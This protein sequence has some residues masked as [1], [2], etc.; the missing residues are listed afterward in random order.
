MSDFTEPEVLASFD[1]TVGEHKEQLALEKGEFRGRP[2]YC[3]RLRWQNAE[4]AWRWSQAKASSTGRY[5]A[6]LTVKAREL[7]ELGLALVAE[8]DE[9]EHQ[10]VGRRPVAEPP[11]LPS[12]KP[13]ECEQREL[14]RFDAAHPAI[15]NPRG[16]P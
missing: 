16:I 15:A 3:L 6:A 1:R 11:N 8:A 12:R 2:T 9:L 14:D 7:R 13:S 10:R 4:G 5:F